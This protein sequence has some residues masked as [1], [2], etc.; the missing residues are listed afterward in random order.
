MS[1]QPL[2]GVGCATTR[3]QFSS[4]TIASSSRHLWQTGWIPTTGCG[5]RRP[6]TPR[7]RWRFWTRRRS[8]AYSATTRCRRFTASNATRES[9]R[10]NVPF[11]LLTARGDE[12]L[13]SRAIRTGVDEY[14]IERSVSED[15]PLELLV[16][17]IRN[18]VEKRR[19][20]QTYERLLENSPDEISQVSIDGEST[21]ANEARATAHGYT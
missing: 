8:T 13:A 19:T 21:A 2:P 7:P 20:P 10:S 11:I 15:E 9:P 5:R 14:V 1:R 6:P 18:V 17:R 4:S 16:D 3:S 12:E